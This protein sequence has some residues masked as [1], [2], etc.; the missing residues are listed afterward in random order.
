M[1]HS[2]SYLLGYKYAGQSGWNSYQEALQFA[3]TVLMPL[4]AKDFHAGWKARR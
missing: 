4:V 1:E 3:K 2:E